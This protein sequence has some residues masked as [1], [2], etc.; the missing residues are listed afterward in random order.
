MV[1]L[2]LFIWMVRTSYKI[3]RRSAPEK[4]ERWPVRYA[5]P[6]GSA[7]NI[8]VAKDAET[9]R[10]RKLL[11]RLMAAIAVLFV[12]FIVFVLTR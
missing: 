11:L 8:N 12:V 3:E 9:Q 4:F 2:A 10:L 5:N 6:I 7:L 1:T